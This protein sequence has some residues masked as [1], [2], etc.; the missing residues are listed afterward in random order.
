[1]IKGKKIIAFIPARGGSKGIKN[2]NILEIHGK[3]LIA[4]TIEAAKESVYI[5]DIVVSTDSEQIKSIA[6]EYGAWLPFLRPSEL[7]E[8]ETSTLDVVLH[9]IA[10]LKAQG[11]T[12]DILLLLQPTSP[13]RTGQDIDGA[14]DVFVRNKYQPVAAVSKVSDHPLLMRKVK[15]NG[16]MEKIL[17]VQSSVRRQDMP[18]YYKINGSIYINLVTD[19]SQN[20]SFNDNPIPYIMADNHAIDI[21]D[22]LDIAVLKFYLDDYKKEKDS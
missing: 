3:P 13:L 14:L 15:E 10:T 1:M 19:L 11:Y 20:T 7:A 18:V 22:E 4:Y 6:E 5:D 16:K 17:S 2:K 21:D 9:T 8:D 12:Y